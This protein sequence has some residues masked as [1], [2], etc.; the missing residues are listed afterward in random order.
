MASNPRFPSQ[1]QL[2]V[3]LVLTGQRFG[4]N[5]NRCPVG[6]SQVVGLQYLALLGARAGLWTVKL[7][8]VTQ[9]PP[10]RKKC[11]QLP[12]PRPAAVGHYRWV[13]KAQKD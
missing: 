2:Q 12:G 1:R 13:E 10:K 5:P 4:Q 9:H 11:C 7:V 3:Q 8:L 6:E